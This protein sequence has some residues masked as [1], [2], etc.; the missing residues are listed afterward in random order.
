MGS[1]DWQIALRRVLVAIV[2]S[3]GGIVAVFY[4]LAYSVGGSGDTERAVASGGATRPAP[5][6][7]YVGN[8]RPRGRRPQKTSPMS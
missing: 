2:L 4:V 7:K 3:V 1:S 8:G 6:I 5:G